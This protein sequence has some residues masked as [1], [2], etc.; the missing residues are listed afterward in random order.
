MLIGE[1]VIDNF[2]NYTFFTEPQQIDS[3]NAWASDKEDNYHYFILATV[4][5]P[6]IAT[7][8]IA[9]Y[10]C[11]SSSQYARIPEVSEDIENVELR[12]ATGAADIGGNLWYQV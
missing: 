1:A 4:M 3:N 5:V 12:S 2:D 9:Y 7:I 6:L 10:F 8:G 11:Y